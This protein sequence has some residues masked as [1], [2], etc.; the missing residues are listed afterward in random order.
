MIRLY[1]WKILAEL[2]RL[3]LPEDKKNSE[4]TNKME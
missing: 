3:S 1:D 4:Q 2:L